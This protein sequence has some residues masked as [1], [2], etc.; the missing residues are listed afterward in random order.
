MISRRIPRLLHKNGW[1]LMLQGLT[2]IY[3]SQEQIITL[4]FSGQWTYFINQEKI[5]GL[6]VFP[7]FPNICHHINEFQV[8]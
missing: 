8:S 2:M 5:Y 7:P 4:I 3:N 1:D 6:S